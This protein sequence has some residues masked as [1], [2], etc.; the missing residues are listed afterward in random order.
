MFPSYNV[1]FEICAAILMIIVYIFYKMKYTNETEIGIAF[2]RILISAICTDVL[3]VASTLTIEYADLVP[4]WLNI[5]LS[6]LYFMS[7]A[8]LAFAFVLYIVSFVYDDP[9]VYGGTKA[10][11]ILVT[12]LWAAIVV[13][14]FTGFL[15][16]FDDERVYHRGV[17]YL[18]LYIV[19]YF[20]LLFG[21][22]FIIGKKK[23]YS[24]G[25]FFSILILI[26]FNITGAVIQYF[27]VPDMLITNYLVSMGLLLIFFFLETPDFHKMVK[28]LADLEVMKANLLDEV[29]KKTKEADDRRQKVE[30]MSLQMV[31]TLATTIDAKD[32]YTNGHSTRVAEYSVLLARELGWNEEA[33]TNLRYKGLLHDI[34]K[35]G[36]ADAIL[37]K[38]SRL[39]KVEYE[40]IQSHTTMGADILKE[41]SFLPGSEEVA[42]YHHE[43][44]DGN[45]YPE[46]LKGDQIPIE[47]RIVAIAD[48]FDAM[49]SDRIYRK[50]LSRE[51][52]RKEL[53][54]GRGKQFDP[55]YLDVFVRLYDSGRL[56]LVSID[57]Y[58]TKSVSDG[59]ERLMKKVVETMQK[60][61]VSQKDIISGLMKREDGEDLIIDETGKECG[62]LVLLE[63]SGIREVNEAAGRIVGDKII[64]TVG[65]ILI[66]YGTGITAC[67]NGGCGFL[68]F[69]RD[70]DDIG[71]C[72]A[73]TSIIQDYEKEK[74]LD[75]R[76]EPSE[77][78]AGICMVT[79]GD[80]YFECYAKA[81]KA[82]YHIRQAGG[83]GYFFYKQMSENLGNTSVDL[84]KL[85]SSIKSSC[86]GEVLDVEYED[87]TKFYEY[88][89]ALW[90]RY[91]HSF[92][93]TMVTLNSSGTTEKDFDE[94]EK[95]MN[96]MEVAIRHTIRTVD[97]CTRYSSSQI[98]IIL[99][100]VGKDNVNMVIR[101][102]F[103][104]YYKMFVSGNIEVS[105]EI[106]D[107]NLEDE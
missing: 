26:T 34:G 62:A 66:D 85:V 75:P 41:S 14:A 51:I 8:F 15:F 2:K 101:R 20:C 81:D 74:R 103:Q 45:G 98:L 65:K 9:W 3:S 1:D 59:S 80:D 23:Y 105:Y 12:L 19:P 39:K 68:L 70:V 7:G 31:Q 43:R 78:F 92:V 40:V 28:T 25:Q 106:S 72:D 56:D 91:H 53:L 29:D 96:C 33:V 107:L 60:Q 18:L 76:M 64:A 69:I 93:L 46:G 58:S 95:A 102:I 37:N 97:I 21:A 54:E 44:Y 89:M 104:D 13:N 27:F 4:K 99:L 87:F 42:R 30:L 32:R 61:N 88:I 73:M 6:S 100:E 24:A 22:G 82:L 79:P 94:L 67:R 50:A 86:S 17:L 84:S 49:N 10:L 38:P 48:A 90:K 35:I 47:A 36:V 57:E 16:F 52:I 77:L 63:I 11:A 55:V 5:T 83:N 71:T